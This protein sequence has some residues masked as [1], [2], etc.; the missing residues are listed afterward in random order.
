MEGSGP[1]TELEPEVDFD[2]WFSVLNVHYV[3]SRIIISVSVHSFL[4]KYD[5]RST[6]LK[7]L[8]FYFR[9]NQLDC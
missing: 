3:S 6:D 4:L 5:L 2:L 9:N 7:V 1:L 8:S